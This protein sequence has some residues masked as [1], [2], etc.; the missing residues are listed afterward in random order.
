MYRG[1]SHTI[2]IPGR[3]LYRPG[4]PPAVTPL[5]AMQGAAGFF[6]SFKLS[7][8]GAL[9]DAVVIASPGARNKT[10]KACIWSTDLMQVGKRAERYAMI[11]RQLFLSLSNI[12]YGF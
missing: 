3:D 10:P 2:K 11:G 9:G 6:I 8:L 4:K 7:D 12:N 1:F 5:S